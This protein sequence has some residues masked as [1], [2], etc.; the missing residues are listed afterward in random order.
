MDPRGIELVARICIAKEQK[1]MYSNLEIGKCKITQGKVY[2]K[3]FECRRTMKCSLILKL[4]K[5]RT[6]SKCSLTMQLLIAR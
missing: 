6:K 1:E 2:I 4:L 5:K 3:S